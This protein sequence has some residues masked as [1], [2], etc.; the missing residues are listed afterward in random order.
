ME[1][2]GLEDPSLRVHVAACEPCQETVR[3]AV[4]MRRLAALPVSDRP[5]PAAAYIWWKAELLRQWDAQQRIVRPIEVGERVGVGVGIGGATA[6]LIWLW[7]QLVTP[8]AMSSIGDVGRWLTLPG[9]L[10]LTLVATGVLVAATAAMAITKL[11][12]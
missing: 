8:D 6:L 12:T 2:R 3:V 4:A 5:L 10:T 9:T 1:I 7:R 11:R